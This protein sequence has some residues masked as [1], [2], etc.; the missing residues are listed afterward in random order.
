MLKKVKFVR[1]LDTNDSLYDQVLKSNT[2]YTWAIA[3]SN[4]GSF[5]EHSKDKDF[6][7]TIPY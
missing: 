4:A 3:Y 6:S 2:P 5:I 1:K 7:I